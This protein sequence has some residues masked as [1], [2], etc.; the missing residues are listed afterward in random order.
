MNFYVTIFVILLQSSVML[1]CGPNFFGI[2]QNSAK[3][4][5]E[6][7]QQT[8]NSTKS[9]KQEEHN[10]RSREEFEA[11]KHHDQV[12]KCFKALGQVVKIMSKL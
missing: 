8:L 10:K 1:S 2:E 7:V 12:N 11:Q 5:Q 4:Y 3:V 9:K 6:T